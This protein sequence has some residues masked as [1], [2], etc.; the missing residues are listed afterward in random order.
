M[1]ISIGTVDRKIWTPD[2][3]L[4][5]LYT[6]M[7]TNDELII[8][9]GPDGP[10]ATE[11]GLYYIL[12]EFCNLTCYAK[13]KITIKT[14]NMLESHSVYNIKC[15]PTYWYEVKMIQ[16]WLIGKTITTTTTPTKHF[17]NFISRT[18]WARLWIATLLNKYYSDKV[19]QTYHYDG[20]QLNYNP[21]RYIGIDDLIKQGC[22][23]FVDSAEFISQCPKTLDHLTVPDQSFGQD[24]FYPIQHPANLN[25]LQYYN[26]IFVDVICETYTSGNCFLA[27]EKIWR[28]IIAQRPFIVMS[29]SN[30][31]NNLKRLGFKT[32]EDFWSE[33]YD[34]FKEADRI[35]QIEKVLAYIAKWSAEQLSDQ[36]LAMQP[37]LDH[38]LA[39]FKELNYNKISKAFE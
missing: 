1:E 9:L 33:E 38:N 6:C 20:T 25:L 32:F 22:D 2:I 28:P 29:N 3:I 21:N 4:K 8:D 35:K 5:S 31:L 12:D 37:I 16:Q 11:L 26:D 14:A 36:L 17:A 24:S 27:T 34:L 18:S 7:L 15:D 23:I 19:V 30:Y 13:N 39:V 10:C